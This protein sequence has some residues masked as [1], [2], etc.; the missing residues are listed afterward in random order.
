MPRSRRVMTPITK[1][2]KAASKPPAIMPNHGFSP[3]R[4]ARMA[5]V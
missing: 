3:R 5:E 1:P 4:S 2:R